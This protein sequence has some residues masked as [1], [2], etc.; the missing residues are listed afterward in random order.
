MAVGCIDAEL[1]RQYGTLL[2]KEGASLWC[3]D[4]IPGV[5]DHLQGDRFD[6]LP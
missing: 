3:V 4:E 5:T 1:L 2:T 6:R